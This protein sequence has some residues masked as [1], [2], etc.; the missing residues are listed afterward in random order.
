MSESV[1]MQQRGS[2]SISMTDIA[3]SEHKDVPGWADHMDVQ[4]MCRTRLPLTGFSAL[5]TW[6]NLS[7]A[8]SSTPE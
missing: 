2:V 3:T 7:P 8:G 4:E 5:E 1:A 6:P